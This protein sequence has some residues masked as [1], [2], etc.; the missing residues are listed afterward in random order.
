[1][2]AFSYIYTPAFNAVVMCMYSLN[3]L[4][5]FFSIGRSVVVRV[6]HFYC[7]GAVFAYLGGKKRN[8]NESW[9]T[10]LRWFGFTQFLKIPIGFAVGTSQAYRTSLP[11]PNVI[12]ETA[13]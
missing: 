13:H 3:N 4:T 7:C 6:C 10:L 2:W 11:A 12:G 8:E 9:V 5:I 1:M